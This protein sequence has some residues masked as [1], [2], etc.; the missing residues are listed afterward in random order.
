MLNQHF[1]PSSENGFSMIE[2]LVA[3]VIISFGL[4]GVA[5][6]QLAS[7]KTTHSAQ[8]RSQASILAYDIIDRMRAN[9]KLAIGGSYNT[10]T[11]TSAPESA[12]NSYSAIN[13][14]DLCEWKK[15]I[16]QFLPLGKASVTVTTS[17]GM[18]SILIQWDD[19][20]GGGGTTQRF[21]TTTQLCDPSGASC[22]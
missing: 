4:L 8:Y 10:T 20:R 1:Q 9:R 19:S 16:E 14:R 21:R 7:L 11:A 6:L 17:T 2:T 3:I 13:T 22:Q 5:G 15:N 12:C 18:A